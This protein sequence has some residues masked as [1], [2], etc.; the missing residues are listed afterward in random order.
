MLIVQFDTKTVYQVPNDESTP[1]VS[2]NG[3]EVRIRQD[4]G[5][6]SWQHRGGIRSDSDWVKSSDQW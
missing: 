2:E 3:A 6:D 1:Q 4:P 5:S